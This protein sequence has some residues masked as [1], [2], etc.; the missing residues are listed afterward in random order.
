MHHSKTRFSNRV[1]N[2]VRYRPHYPD[3]LV[4][5]LEEQRVLQGGSIV[6]DVGSGT[7]ISTELF[8]KKGYSC[9]GVEPNRDM[10]LAAERELRAY[11]AFTS[12]E[13]SAEETGLEENSVD[14]VIAGQAFHWFD[15]Q[16]SKLEFNRILKTGG[17][18]ALLWNKRNTEGSAF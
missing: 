9:I 8:L 1:D 6:A 7:G 2:Y 10:R 17:H 4:K 13:G 14:L 18:V 5:T 15:Q 12:A 3:A 16:A 11:P